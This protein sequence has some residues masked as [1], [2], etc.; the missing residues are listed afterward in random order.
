MYEIAERVLSWVGEGRA[1]VLARTVSVEG[2]SSRWVGEA[3]ARLPNGESV[4]QLLSGAADDRLTAATRERTARVVDLAIGDEQ[5]LAAGLSCGGQARVLVQPAAQVPE[6]AWS[7][8]AARSAVCLVTDL[9]GETVG[10]TT[11]FNAD[12][13]ALTSGANERHSPDI[14][15][16]FGRGLTQTALMTQDGRRLLVSSLWPATR[17]VIVGDGLLATALAR[18]AELL[19]W[20]PNVVNEVEPA[21]AAVSELAA[22]DAV[23]VL[24]H[25]RDVDGPVL[26]AALSGRVGYVGAL[27][28]RRT[29]AARATWLTD[30]GV[31]PEVIAGIRGPA[32]LDIGART[33]AEI[34]LSILAEVL[35][36]RTGGQ[37]QALRDR[38]GPIHTD[39]LNTPP[40]RYEP[41]TR[42]RA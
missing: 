41:A 16:W 33:P 29:Q 17:L 6:A 18:A 3:F 28:S 40:A 14:V 31:T 21:I 24:T 9:D 27:G 20:L 30:R 5:A 19:D 36:V 12:A 15:R 23:V 37:G 13:P 42:P 7:A 11:W 1:P 25:S 2:M 38:S 32:G 35:S 4:G 39:G 26:A 8:L 34:A 22:G 10:E